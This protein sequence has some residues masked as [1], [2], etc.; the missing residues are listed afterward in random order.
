MSKP[1]INKIVGHADVPPAELVAHDK[2]FRLHP[3][4]Q[5]EA[6]RGDPRRPEQ[7]GCVD[8]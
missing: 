7:P 3:A 6:S 5:K 1:W 8:E 2:N 4:S